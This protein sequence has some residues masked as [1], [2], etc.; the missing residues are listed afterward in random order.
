MGQL[1]LQ[2][3]PRRAYSARNFFR[4]HGV[5]DELERMLAYLALDEF[6]LLE[7]SAPEK[8]GLTHL[9]ITLLTELSDRG[10]FPRLIEGGE[11]FEWANQRTLQTVVDTGEVIIVDDADLYLKQVALFDSG[12]FVSIVE[13]LRKNRAAL[14]LLSHTPLSSIGFDEHVM[15]RLRAGQQVQIGYPIDQDMEPLIAQMAVQRGVQLSKRNLEYLARRLPRDIRGID[16]YLERAS[17]LAEVSG[18]GFRLPVLS[19]AITKP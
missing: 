12:H 2:I 9:S 11:F 4:H 15:S 8:C 5:A 13:Q 19:D 1:P 3:I 6:R 10:F 7:V 17:Q 14:V 18:K 16:Q